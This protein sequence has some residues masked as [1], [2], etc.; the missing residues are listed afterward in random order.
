MHSF[1]WKQ[2]SAF[3]THPTSSNP[4]PS[5]SLFFFFSF[6]K[7]PQYTDSPLPCAFTR[8]GS[9]RSY[10]TSTNCKR[11]PTSAHRNVT[12]KKNLSCEVSATR[13]CCWSWWRL[14]SCSYFSCCKS[15]CDQRQSA[16]HLSARS[17]FCAEQRT[18]LRRNPTESATKHSTYI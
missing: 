5:K 17:S 15:R 3:C 1:A 9:V 12:V 6:F 4:L 18:T 7:S 13:A 14:S 8:P 10:F 2:R 11:P 16:L